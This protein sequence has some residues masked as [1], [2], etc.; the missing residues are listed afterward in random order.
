M[1]NEY[2]V[3][4][5]DYNSNDLP[6]SEKIVFEGTKQQCSDKVKWVLANLPQNIDAMVIKASDQ[7]PLGL[8]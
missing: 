2:Q 1:S 4:Q 5:W 8:R 7:F 6:Q 3:I